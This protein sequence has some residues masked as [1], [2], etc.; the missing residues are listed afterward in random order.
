MKA[1]DLIVKFIVEPIKKINTEQ[2][3]MLEELEKTLTSKNDPYSSEYL[4]EAQET[5]KD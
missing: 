5:L 2:R 4:K 1:G 3:K